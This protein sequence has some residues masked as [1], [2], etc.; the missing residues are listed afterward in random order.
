MISWDGSS[1]PARYQNN[2]SAVHQYSGKETALWSFRILKDQK[3]TELSLFQLQDPRLALPVS[4]S[5]LHP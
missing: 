2:V 1:V 4:S 5:L 3:L